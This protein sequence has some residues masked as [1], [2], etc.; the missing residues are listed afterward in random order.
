MQ[1]QSRK[2]RCGKTLCVLWNYDLL[3][4]AMRVYFFFSKIDIEY[5]QVNFLQYPVNYVKKA[6]S[7]ICIEEDNGKLTF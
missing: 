4:K 1:K 6:H 5:I 7:V 2:K 3:K